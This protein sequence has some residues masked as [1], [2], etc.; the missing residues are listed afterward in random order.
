[1]SGIKHGDFHTLTDIP[2]VVAG[3]GG[4]QI[5]TGRHVMYPEPTPFPNLLL[6]LMDVMGVQR[7]KLGQSTGHLDGV[8]SLANF[9]SR[10][11][12]D[13]S[14]KVLEDSGKKIRAKGLLTVSD[15]INDTTVYYL[16]LSNKQ[17]LE[18]RIPFLAA[19]KI[20][21]DSNVGRVITIDGS[22]ST[23][24]GRQIIDRLTYERSHKQ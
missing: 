7:E 14:W 11:V 15:D 21:L 3:N 8:S 1:M 24:Q 16:R 10:N 4:G 17:S 2:V 13:G 18:I 6:K 22:Y 5:K 20:E 19:H 23:K 9:K 12:D